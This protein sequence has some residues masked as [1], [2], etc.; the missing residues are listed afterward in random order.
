MFRDI[1]EKSALEL[2]DTLRDA[3][4]DDKVM[5]GHQNAGHIGVSIT[6]KDGTQSDV[7]NLVGKHPAVVGI[8]TLSF[9]GYEGYKDDL[10]KV[11]KQLHKE[12]VIITLSA[13]MPNFSLGDDKYIDYTP[14]ITEGNVGE[15]I[16][17]G[18]DLNGKYLKFLNMIADFA[19]ECIDVSGDR[20]PMI[21]R[22]FHED[23]G[24]WFWWG[25]ESLSDDKFIK[26]FRYTVEYLRDEKGIRNFLYAYS[27]NGFIESTE[28]YMRR[29]PGDDVIDIMG[30]DIYHDRPVE[31]DGFVEKT[32]SSLEIISKCADIHGKI[33]A[34]T[35][36][37]YRTLDADVHGNYYEGLAPED[38]VM[39]DWFTSVFKKVLSGKYGKKCAYALVWANFSDTQFWLPYIKGDFKHEM[40][41]DFKEFLKDVKLAP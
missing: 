18:G 30:M 14:N 25:A 8:D 9:L 34:L 33:T 24:N 26:L 5:F 29:Y 36:I 28:K 10:V 1:R 7:K 37:G 35:E 39:Q 38:N 23:S 15:R 2:L 40:A 3:A 22:P 16:M 13:H 20:I 17:P 4:L 21:F 41:D 6:A 11:V 12:G 19:C 27:P 32:E 31:G